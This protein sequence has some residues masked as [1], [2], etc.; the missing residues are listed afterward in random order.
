MKAG[1]PFRRGV[2]LPLRKILI[3]EDGSGST[4]YTRNFSWAECDYWS[5][6]RVQWKAR[7]CAFAARGPIAT[8]VRI[9]EN[10][11]PFGFIDRMKPR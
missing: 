11:G 4:L 9:R 1:T 10:R 2:M 7:R 3:C 6:S 5:S 8:I